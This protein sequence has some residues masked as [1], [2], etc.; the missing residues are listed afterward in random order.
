[1]AGKFQQLP[2]KREGMLSWLTAEQVCEI[3]YDGEINIL[4]SGR[5]KELFWCVQYCGFMKEAIVS[6]FSSSLLTQQWVDFCNLQHNI[7]YCLL[8]M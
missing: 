6:I 1:M 5:E 7:V 2:P 3:D 8:D 4:T